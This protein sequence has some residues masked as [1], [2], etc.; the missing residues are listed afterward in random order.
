MLREHYAVRQAEETIVVHICITLASALLSLFSMHELAAA[1]KIFLYAP[2]LLVAMLCML[3][4]FRGVP[5]WTLRWMRALGAMQIFLSLVLLMY[6]AVIILVVRHYHAEWFDW[7]LILLE[8]VDIV[9]A[10][11]YLYSSDQIA[12]AR[13]IQSKI[14]HAAHSTGIARNPI[15]GRVHESTVHWLARRLRGS[16]RRRDPVH[17]E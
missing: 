14:A 3:V 7:V 11:M 17:E 13:S 10:V 4:L 16:A 8:L 5:N 6:R 15:V 2:V 9:V 12:Y 1:A